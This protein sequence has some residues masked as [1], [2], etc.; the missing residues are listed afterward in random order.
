MS[1][2]ALVVNLYG[3]PGTGKSS[4]MAGVFHDL[5]WRGVNCEMAPEFAKEKVWEQSFKI[6]ENQI[7][8]FGKQ[9]HS[10]H[11]LADQVSVIVTDSPLLL[12]LVYGKNECEQFLDL[13]RAVFNRYNNLNIFLTRNPDKPYNPKGRVQTEDKATALDADIRNALLDNFISYTE[14][15]A[16]PKAVE[17]IS[18]MVMKCLNA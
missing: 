7:Y 15:V 14:M 3:G 11:R 10:I 13:V 2:G 12:S 4:L 18:T 1:S 5:K 16:S 17:T 6:L 8:I 9:L